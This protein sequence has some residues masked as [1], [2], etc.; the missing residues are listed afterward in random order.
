MREVVDARQRFR[1]LSPAMRDIHVALSILGR[2]AQETA[3][4]LLGDS[5][6]ARHPDTSDVFFDSDAEKS[7]SY[8]SE[9]DAVA[10]PDTSHFDDSDAVEDECKVQQD[11]HLSFRVANVGVLVKAG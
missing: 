6:G 11:Q 5:A 4:S 3:D 10:Y 1:Q 8:F 2:D 7:E 9:S